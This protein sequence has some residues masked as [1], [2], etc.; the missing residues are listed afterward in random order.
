MKRRNYLTDKLETQ[1]TIYT[2]FFLSRGMHSIE[3]RRKALALQLE[4]ELFDLIYGG[5]KNDSES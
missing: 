4:Y 3:A 2:L 5:S 1:R